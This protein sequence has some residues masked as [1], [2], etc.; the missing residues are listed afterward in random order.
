MESL[1]KKLYY[2]TDSPACYAGVTKLYNEAKKKLPQ[3]KVKDVQDFL[4]KQET[5]TLHRPVKRRF[6]RNRIVTAG[7]DVDWQADLADLAKLKQ[8]NNNYTFI[9]R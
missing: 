7:L 4:S 9:S 8:Y 3:I 2:S 5:Y 6:P 1:L